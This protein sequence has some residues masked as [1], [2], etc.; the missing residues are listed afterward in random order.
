MRLLITVTLVLICLTTQGQAF[1]TRNKGRV[2]TLFI[3]KDI[4]NRTLTF[5]PRTY[6]NTEALHT[7]SSGRIVIIQNSKRK[8]GGSLDDTGRVGYTAA[9]GKHFGYAIFWTRVINES[10]A[11]LELTINFPA[12]S[13][14]ISSSPGSY[15][16]L[17]LPSDTM[18][19]AKETA[20][21]YGATGLKSFLDKNFNKR[22]TLQKTINP[23]GDYTFYVLVLDQHPDGGVQQLSLV[24]EEQSLFYSLSISGQ[25]NRE[26]IPSGW[27]VFKK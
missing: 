2:D 27:I 11:P 25:R 1:Q 4:F 15:F 18:T 21:N 9:D 5:Y 23:K 12:D 22:T 24:L 8:A 14:A 26:L 3:K 17:F 20:Y 16:K 6:I 13:F 7:D 19:L 10:A